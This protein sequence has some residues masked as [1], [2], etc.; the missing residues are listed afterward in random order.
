MAS[1]SASPAVAMSV[2]IAVADLALMGDCACK[3][4][5]VLC[6]LGEDG[7]LL[8]GFCTADKDGALVGVLSGV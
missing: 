5:V 6:M 2:D 3:D 4:G 8:A 7:F 1:L